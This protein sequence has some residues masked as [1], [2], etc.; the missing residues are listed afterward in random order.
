M[1]IPI[2]NLTTESLLNLLKNI[3]DELKRRENDPVEH[4]KNIFK[5]H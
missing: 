5:M 2:K 3:Q 1:K 4:L